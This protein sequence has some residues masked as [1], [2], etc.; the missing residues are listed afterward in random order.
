MLFEKM[1]LAKPDLF[2]YDDGSASRMFLIFA[3]RMGVPFA[4]LH[5]ASE[6]FFRR[7]PF[8]PAV[9]PVEFLPV[10]QHMTFTERLTNFMIYAS[11][12]RSR[13]LRPEITLPETNLAQCQ[14]CRRNSGFTCKALASRPTIVHGR[15]SG[16]VVI[17]SFG[18]FVLDLPDNIVQKFWEVFREIPFKV[19]FRSNLPSPDKRKLLTLPW[20]PQ[21]DLLAHPNTKVFVTHCGSSGQYQALYHAVPM[22]GLPISFDQLYNAERMRIKNFGMTLDLRSANVSEIAS[23]IKTVATDRIYKDAITHASHLFRVEFG[24]P[25]ERAAFWLDH[26]MLYGG[27][28]MRSAG[29]EIPL[30]QFY[31]MDVLGFLG[32]ML[33]IC[34]CVLLYILRLAVKKFYKK[35]KVD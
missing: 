27:A 20:F 3:Y 16:G 32:A 5:F 4:G 1:K 14:G 34:L 35:R 9:D 21:N 33:V 30:Y 28:Y 17:V 8:S 2:V 7:I 26:V 13:D 10:G 23:A 25:A 12:E 19:I 22:V 6:P 18:S 31:L 15:C 11:Q 29:Q 24:V